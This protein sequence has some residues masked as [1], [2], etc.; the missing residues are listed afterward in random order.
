MPL[1]MVV[2]ADHQFV[3]TTSAGY[4]D[5]LT[6]V[7]IADGATVSVL[8]FPNTKKRKKNGLYYGIA[9][10]AD[11]LV[12]AAQG[13]NHSVAVARVGADGVLHGLPEIPEG[14]SDFSA[15]LAA[16][17]KGRLFI[18]QNDP[19]QGEKSFGTPASMAVVEAKSGKEIG[20]YVFADEYGLSNFPLS[21]TVNSAGTRAYVASERDSCV[22]VLNTEVPTKIQL[23]AKV[24]T[25]ANP[26]ALLLNKSQSTLYVANA[27]SD[28]VSIVD[29]GTLKVTGTILLRPQIAKDLAGATPTGLALSESEKMLYV[30]L[31]DMNAVAVVDLAEEEGPEVEGYIPTGWYP[32]SV[33]AVGRQ[34]LV[35]NAKGDVARVPH[36]F[37]EG[38]KRVKSP[39]FL[40]EGTLWRMEIP[41]KEELAALTQQ[42]LADAHLTPAALDGKNPLQAVSRL[43]GKIEHVI[44]VIKENRTYDQ[45]LGDLPQGNGDKERCIF[46][47]EVTPNLHA[48]AERFVLLDNFYDSG[49]VSGDGW[50][51]S[52]QAQANEYT[53]RNVPYQYSGR[54]RGF[55]Y[56]GTNNDYPTGGFPAV[57]PDGK[58]L[59]DDPRF[60]AG[61]KPVPDV[62]GSPG[63][64]LWDL[65]RKHELSYR[66]FGFFYTDGVNSL[67]RVVIPDNYPTVA[68]VQP[69]GHDLDG[70]SDVDYRRFDLDFPDSDAPSVL[71]GKTG[72]S[73]FLW[74]E[75]AFGQNKLPSR[76]SEWKR[77]FGLM[78]AKDPS[79]AGV[80][81]FMTLR[82]GT[83][84][85]MGANPNRPT[86]RCMVA[87]ND[88]AVGELVDAVSHSPIWKSTAIVILEDDAQNGP[89]HVDAHRSICLVISPWVKQGSVDHTFQNT[90]SAIKTMESLLNLPPMC[91]Y[92]AAAPVIADF[93]SSPANDQPYAA[94][95]PKEGLMK[96]RNGTSNEDAPVSPEQPSVPKKPAAAIPLDSAQALVNVSAR[97]DFTHADQAPADLLNRIIWKTVRG[98]ASE[99]PPTPH[100]IGNAPVK[101]DDGD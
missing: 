78:L 4:R 98:A 84:H 22:Y 92:D 8:D 52:T 41:H 71:A 39:L 34:L 83:D 5:Q 90:V 101:E 25:G 74:K 38:T 1:N 42:V 45:I 56:E 77:S 100:V 69:G 24:S 67:L 95:F 54:G 93:G 43:A 64:H 58:P 18:T 19:E 6:S 16:D 94:I 96:E 48:L 37:V 12:Y 89:D 76:I 23:V 44:Y 21:V 13:A 88:Y 28:T 82:L 86:P 97:L 20:R 66:N 14:A 32:T 3:I 40:F 81:N 30:T 31:G 61:A 51:W 36:D 75:R 79:G 59:S 35:T 49:E 27:H 60:K 91:Q 7:R 73:H 62:A 47:R 2:T 70:I 68:G 57:G 10:T 65:V 72:D 99:M 63:G 85:T 33:A 17:S 26:D 29:T 80:P 55:D 9:L 53:I 46:G 11:G 50:T 87:D 15:G